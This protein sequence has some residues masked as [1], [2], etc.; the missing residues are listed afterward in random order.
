[1]DYRHA[2]ELLFEELKYL[3]QPI[4]GLAVVLDLELYKKGIQQVYVFDIESEI[5]YQFIN[6]EMAS[7]Y[8]ETIIWTS[9]K[10]K[11]VTMY[12]KK[13]LIDFDL[14][15]KSIYRYEDLNYRP[16]FVKL[17]IKQQAELLIFQLNNPDSEKPDC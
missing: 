4:V 5:Y 16:H 7:T 6:S 1:M 8:R 10:K 2:D 11:S 17:S 12:S 9:L 13:L 14:D 15:S 3:Y